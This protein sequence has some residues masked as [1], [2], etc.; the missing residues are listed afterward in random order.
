MANLQEMQEW[1]ETYKD[2]KFKRYRDAP[3][4]L[5]VF[6]LK[7]HLPSLVSEIIVEAEVKLMLTIAKVYKPRT[8]VL[9]Q[10][11]WKKACDPESCG[12]E[13]YEDSEFRRYM[14]VDPTGTIEVQTVPWDK[15]DEMQEDETYVIEGTIEEYKDKKSLKGLKIVEATEEDIE[16]Q[17]KY[18]EKVMKEDASL[19]QAKPE[20]APKKEKKTK[21]DKSDLEAKIVIVKDLLHMYEG[22]IPVAK[23]DRACKK[24]TERELDDVRMAMGLKLEENVWVLK[25]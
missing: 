14:G 1:A 10:D 8:S 20:K 2:G 5:K 12:R 11:C 3:E 23:F 13:A 6:Y 19:G 25:K 4:S 18:I 15:L 21:E 24:W 9:C 7:F 16:K 22:E 17:T